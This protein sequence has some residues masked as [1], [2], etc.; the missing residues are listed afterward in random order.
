[1]KTVPI[2]GY[3]DKLSG[4]PG[5]RINF[6][7]SSEH[8]GDFTAQLFRSVNADPNPKG[9]GIVEYACDDFFP[10][11][12][13]SSR[14][15]KFEPGSYGIT[16]QPFKMTVDD[17]VRFSVTIFP[18]LKTSSPQSLIEF[19]K[20]CLNL[21]PEGHISFSFG[22]NIVTTVEAISIRSW[23]RVEA[24]INK[25]GLMSIELINLNLSLI[26]I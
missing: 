20:F 26:H 17:N 14:E 21:D 12:S 24:Q 11:Q 8:K 5:D 23:Y 2:V 19:G 18:T 1:M 6:M 4:R 13:F 7:V 3:S 22:S 9:Q 25:T 15:Q 10:K 16:E